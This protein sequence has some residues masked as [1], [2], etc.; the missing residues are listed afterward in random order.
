VSTTGGWTGDLVGHVRRWRGLWGLL[1][2]SLLVLAV[3]ASCGSAADEATA[4]G[5][6]AGQVLVANRQM[7]DPR[8][9]KTI[10]YV[11]AHDGDGAFG[12]VVNRRYGQGSL[13]VLLDAFGIPAPSSTGSVP[14]HYGGPVQVERGFVLHSPDYDGESTI[15]L[16]DWLAFST[17]RDVLEAMAAGNGPKRAVVILGY[18]GWAPQQLDAEI[19]RGD[20][21][22]APAEPSLIFEDDPDKAW[23]KAMERAGIPL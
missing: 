16:K 15:E 4:A 1:A 19:A 23:D 9:A 14:L 3:A 2:V 21:L 6:T 5:S 8:F 7:N 11:V 20:W 12:L 18:A 10:I 22:L 13:Q 17:G